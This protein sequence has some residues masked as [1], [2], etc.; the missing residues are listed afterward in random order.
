MELTEDWI[1]SALDEELTALTGSGYRREK[2]YIKATD[3]HGHAAKLQTKM[4]EA[5]VAQM[6]KWVGHPG[7]PYRT[8]GDFVRDAVAHRLHDMH[9][10]HLNG[11]LDR[12]S[13]TGL[14]MAQL[15]AERIAREGRD[16]LLK[17]LQAEVP[18]MIAEKQ[19]T[20]AAAIIDQVTTD[21]VDWPDAPRKRAMDQLDLLHS[22]VTSAIRSR[23]KS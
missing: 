16:E 5:E 3:G 23:R 6:A 10:F 11:K 12:E 19:I 7:T 13:A 22:Q 20:E 2:Y 4:H 1:T 15:G 17:M 9:E 8:T 21:I 14:M 18:A